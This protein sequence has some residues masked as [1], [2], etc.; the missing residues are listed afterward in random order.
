M[1]KWAILLMLLAFSPFLIFDLE[2]AGENLSLSEMN[3]PF[4]EQKRGA[5][6]RW[7]RDPF[8]I[9]IRPLRSDTVGVDKEA[10]K[11][12]SKEESK[13][14]K[15]VSLSAIIYKGGEGAAIING[16]IVRKGDIVEGME[17]LQVL[18]DRVVLKEGSRVVE[19]RVDRFL[20]KSP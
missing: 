3:K 7:G 4:V 12:A 10:S 15:A 5:S 17:V 13:S 11:D 6:P 16:R 14:G 9:P 8:A 2:A 19:L 1:I 20:P 18:L